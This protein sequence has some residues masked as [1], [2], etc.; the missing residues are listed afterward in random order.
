MIPLVI[1]VIGLAATAVGA[2]IGARSAKF[3]AE[4]NA[5]AARQQV[6]DHGAIE[7]GHWLRQQRFDAYE[8]FLAA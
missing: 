2:L 3:G 4:R 7:H 6:R 5:E 8:S 1:A